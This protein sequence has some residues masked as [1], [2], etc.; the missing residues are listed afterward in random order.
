MRKQHT[1]YTDDTGHQKQLYV[2]DLQAHQ[3]RL[4]PLLADAFA[5]HFISNKLVAD[6]Q[7]LLGELKEGNL[8]RLADF[9]STGAG[10]KVRVC[11]EEFGCS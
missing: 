8:S 10:L 11:I 7:T 3:L 9:H 4:M 2:L 5:I 1:V 6:Y